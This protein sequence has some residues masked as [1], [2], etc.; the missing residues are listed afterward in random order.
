MF[1]LVCVAPHTLKGIMGRTARSSAVEVKSILSESNLVEEK[2]EELNM[3]QEAFREENETLSP[4]A[5]GQNSSPKSDFSLGTAAAA[6][7]DGCATD[8][9][10]PTA[11]FTLTHLPTEP[12][13]KEFSSPI[14]RAQTD[15]GAYVGKVSHSLLTKGVSLLEEM[16]LSNEPTE[17]TLA[18][19]SSLATLDNQLTCV[20][21]ITPIMSGIVEAAR[22][23]KYNK[24]A[25][26]LLSDRVVEVAAILYDLL[27]VKYTLTSYSLFYARF[28]CSYVYD[29]FVFF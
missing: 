20:S 10:V 18:T 19:I 9:A 13:P 8:V 3:L 1:L 14:M 11:N 7:N 28:H 26:K 5:S 15:H 22:E 16:D 4:N 27:K 23:A 6:T 12:V 29:L 2:I 17:T 25:A 21:V 24:L